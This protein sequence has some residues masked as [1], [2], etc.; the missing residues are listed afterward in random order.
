MTE[1]K[2][3]S[4]KRINF[5]SLEAATD[6]P[7]F[8]EIQLKS[9]RDFF[10]LD[11]PPEKRAEEG[12]YKVFVENFPI[13]DARGNFVLE[14]VDYIVD[15]PKYVPEECIKRGVTYAVPLKAKLRLRQ[16][17]ED[18]EDFETI[19][20][21][22]FLGNI[23]YMTPQGSFVINGS[24][25]V[26]VFQIHKSPGVFFAQSTHTSGTKLY[27]AKIIPFKGAWIEFAT[28]VNSVMYAY[29]DRKKSFPLRLF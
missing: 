3:T 20:Q 27:S 26:V 16:N 29:I 9:F 1:K 18:N 8:L 13:E 4:N 11:N 5:A 12:L 15:T 17:G 19:E 24:E 28:D 23:P 25:R 2:K 22:V 14:L 6:Y 7:D 10:Q 21:E